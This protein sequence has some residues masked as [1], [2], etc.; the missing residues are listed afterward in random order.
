MV[1]IL[2]TGKD[3]DILDYLTKNFKNF[4]IAPN[5]IEILKNIDNVDLIILD[6]EFLDLAKVIKEENPLVKI[7]V[8]VTSETELK[9]LIELEI[10]GFVFSPTDVEELKKVI[11][12][13]VY[14]IN[15][16]NEEKSYLKEI[17]EDKTKKLIT[18]EI[19]G[20]YNM[21]KFKEDSQKFV[22]KCIVI[23]DINDF[24]RINNAFGFEFGDKV[25]KEVGETIKSFNLEEVYKLSGDVFVGIA[26]QLEE[27]D[28]KHYLQVLSALEI[29]FNGFPVYLN[30][31]LIA[32]KVRE[33]DS[34][35]VFTRAFS[36]FKENRVRNSYQI[37]TKEMLEE[38]VKKS[39]KVAYI[40]KVI[41]DSKIV[42][43]FQPIIDNA[44]KK[45]AKYE[46]LARIED[47]GKVITPYFFIDH[48][49]DAGVIKD[50]TK[51]IIDKSFKKIEGTDI[52][53]SINATDE[54]LLEEGFITFLV[55]KVDEYDLI[56]SQITIEILESMS[57]TEEILYKI[58]LLKY[59]GFEISID[60]FGTGYSNFEKF[61]EISPDYLK[62]DGSFIKKL[63]SSRQASKIVNSM[64]I[65]AHAMGS[66]VIAEFIE[67]EELFNRISAMGIE[68]SQG[69]YFAK[70]ER[71][72]IEL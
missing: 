1:R 57:L 16:E 4:I 45:V 36:Y 47:E 56:T 41:R 71:D 54:D 32:F 69:Y 10:N 5:E 2:Y 35:N 59:L 43:Y 60:D 9:E 70:P 62:I 34:I 64:N 48:A 49:K 52:S 72:L 15:L 50:I 12:R 29:D 68:Y 11:E 58:K 61:L 8:I 40:L 55:Q 7:V 63:E 44:T 53:L 25:L 31:S 30:F 27:E 18:D 20:F 23:F 46:V 65:F 17:I 39:Q 22:G 67:N 51:M 42:P 37:V 26:S 38:V 14:L 24:K 19:T 13:V 3:R 21:A 6:R 28:L 33:E 66:K